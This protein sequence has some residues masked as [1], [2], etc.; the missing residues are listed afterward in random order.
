MNTGHATQ[1]APA[2]D[3][4]YFTGPIGRSI[5]KGDGSISYRLLQKIGYGAYS[6][7]WLAKDSKSVFS[8]LCCIAYSEYFSSDNSFK[9]V[10]ILNTF[11]TQRSN[12]L[13]SGEPSFH[14]QMSHGIVP[15]HRSATPRITTGKIGHPGVPKLHRFFSIEDVHGKHDCF[16]FDVLGPQ[17]SKLYYGLSESPIYRLAA[18]KNIVKQILLALKYVHEDCG[19]V[20]CGA[21]HPLLYV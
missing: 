18:A 3:T 20:H 6:N 16:V 8:K 12:S 2:E 4:G 9:A 14:A 10:K 11:A 5:S 21:L 15:Y 7:V 1:Q 17:V 13:H 19:I